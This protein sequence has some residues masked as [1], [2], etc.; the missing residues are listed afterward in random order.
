MGDRAV[1][2]PSLERAARILLY[3]SVTKIMLFC[4][5]NVII[6]SM[7]GPFSLK[8]FILQFSSLIISDFAEGFTECALMH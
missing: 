1:S 3:L 8:T 5:I 7:V 6:Y 2:F 4:V